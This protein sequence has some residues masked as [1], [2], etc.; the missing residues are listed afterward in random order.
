MNSVVVQIEQF[1]VLGAGK[2]VSGGKIVDQILRKIEPFQ[3]R[4]LAENHVEV[5]QIAVGEGQQTEAAV[6]GD[7]D[8]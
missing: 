1:Q 8:F 7:G 4:A 3:R 6:L 5:L 2:G